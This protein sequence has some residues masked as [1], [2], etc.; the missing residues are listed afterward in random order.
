MKKRITKTIT[1]LFSFV[2]LSFLLFALCACNDNDSKKHSEIISLDE[3]KTFNIEKGHSYDISL[4]NYRGKISCRD[5]LYY[6]TFSSSINGLKIT[7]YISRNNGASW[8]VGGNNE[9]TANKKEDTAPILIEACYKPLA[10][11][12][13]DEAHKLSFIAK[14]DC[15]LKITFKQY[16]DEYVRY[17]LINQSYM[18]D[19]L[20]SPYCKTGLKCTQIYFL[21]PKY[22][23][24]FSEI[25]ANSSFGNKIKTAANGLTGKDLAADSA[26]S[27]ISSALDAM[28]LDIGT[29]MQEN[30]VTMCGSMLGTLI[31][32]SL[33]NATSIA[34]A[35]SDLNKAFKSLSSTAVPMRVILNERIYN[36]TGIRVS[37]DKIPYIKTSGKERVIGDYKYFLRAPAGCFGNI[38]KI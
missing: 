7:E 2:I 25:W 19:S 6:I 31:G 20:Y 38:S 9:I 12:P 11:T 37:A 8:K 15:K 34:V 30:L 27:A 24:A 22:A 21:S 16:Q 13:S 35:L 18:W 32:N 36:G 1:L 26:H 5:G 28:S 14:K 33:A 17:D 3:T 29:S 4:S 10:S 23:R